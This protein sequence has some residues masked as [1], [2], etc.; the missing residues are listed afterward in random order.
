MNV[1]NFRT[2][3]RAIEK[4]LEFYSQAEWGWIEMPQELVD[5]DCS[6]PAC[7]GGWC[8]GLFPK[9]S[10]PHIDR[11][12]TVLEISIHQAEDL[13]LASWPRKWFVRAGAAGDHYLECER[14][15]VPDPYQA[16]TILKAIADSGEPWE[17]APL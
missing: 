10:G 4:H 13:A 16:V 2:I 5:E 6:S 14:R 9:I 11:L 7:L 15:I 1:K 12:A 8:R 17:G 3:I